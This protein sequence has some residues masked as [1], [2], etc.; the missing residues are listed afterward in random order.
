MS[1]QRVSLPVGL[2]EAKQRFS[3]LIREV[4]AGREVVATDRGKRLAVLKPVGGDD[5]IDAVL[6]RLEAAGLVRRPARLRCLDAIHVA[7]AIAPRREI[8]PRVQFATADRT[9]HEAAVQRGLRG[10]LIG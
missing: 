10:I 5:E 7:S 4:R 8:G 6:R 3:S 1:L 2:R 9:Q